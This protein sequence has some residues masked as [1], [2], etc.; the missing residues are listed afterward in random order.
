M[1]KKQITELIEVLNSIN[2]KLDI[3]IAQ[4]AKDTK[5]HVEV[6]E[7]DELK[8]RGLINGLLH[9]CTHPEYDDKQYCQAL[10]QIKELDFPI[11][12]KQ[13]AW[14]LAYT[15]RHPDASESIVSFIEAELKKSGDKEKYVNTIA[16]ELRK[17]Y[18]TERNGEFIE[19]IIKRIKEI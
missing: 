6:T 8:T 17:H 11:S 16:F 19:G 10:K 2:S 5:K 9:I 4:S 13:T 1:T 7:S 14:I 3:L 18:A 12:A 15:F